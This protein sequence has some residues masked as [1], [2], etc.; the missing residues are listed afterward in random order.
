MVGPLL[1][2]GSLIRAEFQARDEESNFSVFR[3]RRVTSTSSLN[4]FS[5]R[6]P[7]HIPHSLNASPLFTEKPFFSSLKV[8]HQI[9]FPKSGS[10]NRDWRYKSRLR[11]DPVVRLPPGGHLELRCTVLKGKKKSTKI[12]TSTG[13]N[14]GDSLAFSR[15][16]TTSTGL[17]VLLPDASAPVV[18]KNESPNL[19]NRVA[20]TLR[21]CICVW[22]ATKPKWLPSFGY[23]LIPCNTYSYSTIGCL[24]RARH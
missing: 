15:K 18:V 8:L 9:P 14:F 4:C 19:G 22:K 20:K 11:L 17:P 12:S 23:G 1:L 2:S 24:A 13:N 10:L 3:V 5:C 7:Y 16:I 21:F 6:S